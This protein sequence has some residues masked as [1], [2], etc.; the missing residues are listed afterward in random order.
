MEVHS[1]EEW[2]VPP[3]LLSSSKPSSIDPELARAYLARFS[4]PN[5]NMS[6]LFAG[7]IVLTV[8]IVIASLLLVSPTSVV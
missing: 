7:I 5:Y 1:L 2:R 4:P 3:V 8:G 6:A